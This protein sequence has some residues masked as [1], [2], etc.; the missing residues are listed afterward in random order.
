MYSIQV[1]GRNKLPMEHLFD[2]TPLYKVLEYI[3]KLTMNVSKQY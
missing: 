3:S 2:E 1:H